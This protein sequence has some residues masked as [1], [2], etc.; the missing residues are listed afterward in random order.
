MSPSPRRALGFLALT[1]LVLLA[2]AQVGSLGF[3]EFDDPGY[4]A[5]NPIV[6]RG[7]TWEGT[8]WAFTSLSLGNWHPLTWLSLMAD[9]SL[10][11]TDAGWMHRAN[12][13]WH[14]LNAVLLWVVLE[15]LTG[16]RTRSWLVAAL[17]AVHPLHVE[18][19]AWISER[20]DLLSTFWWLL[21]VAAWQWYVRRPS[22]ERYVAAA[23]SFALGL[24]SKPMVVT[25]PVVLLLLDFWPLGRLA[26]GPELGARLRRL[27]LEKVPLLALSAAASLITIL[28]Q[29]C[30]GATA[31]PEAIPYA[32]R[33]GN[34]ILAAAWYLRKTVWPSSLAV[35]YPNPAVDP[36]GLPMGRVALAALLLLG[37]TGAAIWQ[38]RRRP[39]L[40]F[41]WLWFTVTLLPVIGLVQVGSQ[42]MA[43]RYTYIP[44]IGVFVGLVWLVPASWRAAR[45]SRVALAV[46]CA[47]LVLALATA[48]RAQTGH[49]KDSFTL[50]HHAAHV[51][52]GN[53]LAWKN[54]GAVHHGRGELQL[55]LEAFRRSVEARADQADGWFNLGAAHAALDQH[56]EAAECFRRAVLLAPDDAQAWFALGITRALLGRSGEAAAAV[57]RLRTID[58]ARAQELDALV[59]RIAR[60]LSAR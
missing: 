42:G 15:Q 53:W 21:A 57:E 39:Y 8:R 26:P 33:L 14:L 37:L 20:K 47:A 52:E 43:D 59:A 19:V 32:A 49:W 5:S 4:V 41:G 38:W 55:A 46:G 12:V 25:L 24:L 2:Y 23:A 10:F 11:G 40:L 51:T 22:P 18:S 3:V 36:A 30:G 17:F 13:L 31:T 34:A 7:L 60:Q 45:T 6:Q 44:L 54:L 50:F 58:A 9:V 27:V 35:F 29:D 48:A 16:A 1:A 28:A 56:A